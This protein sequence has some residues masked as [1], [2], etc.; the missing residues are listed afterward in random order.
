MEVAFYLSLAVGILLLI[1][2]VYLGFKLQNRKHEQAFQQEANR[3]K[4][5]EIK[6][7][8]EQNTQLKQELKG[9]LEDYATAKAESIKAAVQKE[10]IEERLTEVK[11][12]WAELKTSL[13]SEFKLIAHDVLNERSR[14]LKENHETSLRLLLTPL[15]EQIQE[16][17]KKVEET[18]LSET[19]EIHNLQESVKE[20]NKQS[21]RLSDQANELTHALRGNSKIQ[22]DWGEHMLTLMLESA[23]LSSPSQYEVQ[24]YIRT[25]GGTLV[26]NEN[27]GKRMRPDVIVH[28]PGNKCVIIDSKV[29]LTAYVQYCNQEVGTSQK[30]YL[31]RHLQSIRNHIKELKKADYA[32]YLPNSPEFI[33]MFIPLEGALTLAMQEVPTLWQEAYNSGVII[34]GPS[35]TIAILKVIHELWKKE[36]QRRNVE[37]I[38]SE[39]TL[40]YDKFVSFSNEFQKIETHINHLQESYKTARNRLTLGRG[41]IISRLVKF[42]QMGVHPRKSIPAQLSDEYEEYPEDKKVL[43]VENEVNNNE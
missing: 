17:K 6:E 2:V 25:E 35:N 1:L 16:F 36:T 20:L 31:H 4:D 3:I 21:G 29:S 27:T 14:T 40:L 15:K 9:A 37:K 19:K 43:E 12:Q 22:G 28:M 10:E 26:T 41:N 11:K 18:H 34:T 7:L 32:Q 24:Q 39:A 23:G 5:N 33:L 42:Q 38:I 13:N 8:T 30:E